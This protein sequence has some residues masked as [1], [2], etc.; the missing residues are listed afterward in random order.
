DS[1][2][3]IASQSKHI[4]ASAL[5]ILVDEGKVNLDDAVE[6]YLPEFQGQMVVAEKDN[7]HVLLKKPRHPITV[8]NVL[9]HTSGLP[10]RS[11]IEV[12]T[13]DRLPL[14]DRVRSYAMTPLEFEPDSKYQY[15]NAGINTAGRIIEVVSGKPYEEFLDERLFKPLGMWDTT[16][17]PTEAQADRIAKSYKPGPNKKGLEETTI[18]QLQYPLSDRRDR[19][20][21]PAGGL[22]STAK[23]LSRFYQMLANNGE[24][25]G[26]RYLS[27][28]AVKQLTSKQTPDGVQNE[29][30][31]GFA[32]GG[33]RFGHGGAYST[34]SYFD[35]KQGLILIWLVQHAGFPGDGDKA[36]DAFRQ[37]ALA[38]FS[39]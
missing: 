12:P 34:N 28:A 16:F 32:T 36:Q 9:S 35:Q 24:L 38:E 5:M 37:A 4:T 17:W 14:A 21:M 2:F 1:M 13:L 22:F 11:G 8:R 31:L 7:N 3:L 19:Y 30:G 15:S 39:K 33:E 6:K 29:Y 25:D 26:K 10:F 23:D 27:E 20:P 18:S